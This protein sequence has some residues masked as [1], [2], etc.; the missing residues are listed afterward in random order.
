MC[1]DDYDG[2]FDP[3]YCHKCIEENDTNRFRKSSLR[4]IIES[5]YSDKGIDIH[6]L[7]DHLHNLCITYNINLPRKD[8]NITKI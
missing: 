5:L 2:C 8:L 6:E 4:K 7:E 1:F 3:Y